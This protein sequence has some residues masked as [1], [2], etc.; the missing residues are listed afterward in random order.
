MTPKEIE[1]T[2]FYKSL[3]DLSNSQRGQVFERYSTK[4]EKALNVKL[5][6]HSYTD[7]GKIKT[8]NPMISYQENWGS[9]TGPVI[10]LMEFVPQ[11]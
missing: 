7:L 5:V 8:D 4:I 1:N 11:T 6:R 9:F 3:L 2:D 10:A